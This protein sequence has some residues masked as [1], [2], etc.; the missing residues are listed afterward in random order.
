M[1]DKKFVLGCMQIITLAR[2]PIQTPESK[3]S[4]IAR[5]R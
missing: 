5:S 3:R 1:L 4:Y 2:K